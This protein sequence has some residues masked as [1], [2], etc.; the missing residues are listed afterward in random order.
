MNRITDFDENFKNPNA[1]REDMVL[2]NVKEA[3]FSLHGFCPTE[4][5]SFRRI[6]YEVA[7]KISK[8]MVFCHTKTSGGRV[9][10]R[11]DSPYII[12]KVKVPCFSTVPHMPVTGTGG[13]DLYADG[14]FV[15]ALFPP[16]TYDG[17]EATFDL[18]DGFEAIATFESK[19]MRNIVINFPLYND[20]DEVFVG[21]S[22]D[23]AILEPLPY[24]HS[25]PI[26]F[27]GSSITQGCCVSRPGNLYM[28]II[29]RWFDTDFTGLGF[30]GNAT[31]GE[32]IANYIAGLDMSMFVYDYDF[33]S[34]S[35][36]HL[37]KTHSEMFSIIRQ[38]HPDIPIIMASRVNAVS[39]ENK[40]RFKIIEEP[41]NN[42]LS[43][44]DKNVYLINGMDILCSID[45]EM[46][47]VDGTHPNDFGSYCMAKAFGEIIKP[48]L[49]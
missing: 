41:Y 49:K 40:R 19:E 48:L 15:K 25:K 39:E 20:V 21:V 7:D 43:Q 26:V 12:L 13:F 47:T 6:P 16:I 24:K 3:P 31:G 10:F 5:D 33:N 38:K 2:Y 42:A 44:G 46:F 45:K 27:Y 8:G 36:E 29:S 22:R 18:K 30:S 37:R 1:Y 32:V 34:P 17:F 28:S 9:R 35:E 4:D 23:S 11:T 14:K